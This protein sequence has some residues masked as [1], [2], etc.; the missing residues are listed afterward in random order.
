MARRSM[1]VALT[2]GPT[3]PPVSAA[4]RSPLNLVGRAAI[5]VAGHVM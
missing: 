1:F 5:G 3:P 2:K 4:A